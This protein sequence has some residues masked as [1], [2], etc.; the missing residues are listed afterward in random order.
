MMERFSGP[1]KVT[2]VTFEVFGHIM[3]INRQGWVIVLLC[4]G[5]AIAQE[6]APIGIVR[7]EFLKWDGSGGK[8]DIELL[9][10]DARVLTCSFDA[11]TFFERDN[12]RIA[13]A[14]MAKGDRLEIVADRRPGSRVCYARTVQVIDPMMIRRSLAARAR[15]RDSASPTELFAPRGDL[16]YAGVVTRLEPDAMVLK[17]RADGEKTILLRSD[18]RYISEGLRVEPATLQLRTRVFVRA[19]KNLDGDVEA[20]QVMWGEIVGARQSQ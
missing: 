1:A 20:Y 16:T 8:G 17:T 15:L 3:S 2:I 13:P 6:A 4:A 19:G 7:G 5:A 10:A 18:T 9:A 11:K 12:Q 14:A